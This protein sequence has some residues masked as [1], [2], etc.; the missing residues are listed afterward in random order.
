MAWRKVLPMDE[1]VRFV[2]EVEEGE[3]N[4][5][6]LCEAYGIS[7]KTGY[8]WW[9]RYEELGMGGLEE[10]VSRPRSCAHRTERWLEDLIEKERRRRPSWGPKKLREVLKEKHGI[11]KPPA[12][13]TIGEILRR[14]KLIEVRGRARRAVRQWEGS[15]EEAGGPN[16]VWG[17]DF[18]GWFRTGDGKRCEPLTISDLYSRY[19]LECAALG[20]QQYEKTRWVYERVFGEYGLPGAMRMDNGTPFGSTGVLG[21]WR[22]SVWWMELG[23]RLEYIEPGHPEQNGIHERMHRTLKAETARPPRRTL[24]AQQQRFNRL[25]K[26]R[27]FETKFQ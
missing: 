23:I 6:E 20:D 21:L 14:K 25:L 4:F 16:A 13:S 27:V 19:V 2:L 22:L 18:K 10:R 9:D 11:G 1:R 7:R 8:K 26:N 12:A 15:Y 17:T 3:G 24:K 5:T